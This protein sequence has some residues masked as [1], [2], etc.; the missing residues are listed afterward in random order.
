MILFLISVGVIAALFRSDLMLELAAGSALIV[1]PLSLIDGAW[2]V[3][4]TAVVLLIVSVF[5]MA[6]HP[7]DA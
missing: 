5:V 1:L 2:D 6:L 7:H 4:L 3:F